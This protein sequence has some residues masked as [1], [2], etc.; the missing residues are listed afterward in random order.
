MAGGGSIAKFNL[1]VPTMLQIN[2]VAPV[3][4]V[5]CGGVYFIT[6]SNLGWKNVVTKHE[7]VN[8]KGILIVRIIII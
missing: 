4:A 6:C 5:A 1:K 3:F 7:K 8:V 2:Y